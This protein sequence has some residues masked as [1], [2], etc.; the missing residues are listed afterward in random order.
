MTLRLIVDLALGSFDDC[1]HAAVSLSVDRR[2]HLVETPAASDELVL[3]AD[4]LQYQY[5]EGPCLSALWTDGVYL[6][7]DVE[8][9]ERWPSWGPR[10]AELGLRSVLSLRLAT[11]ESILAALNL[12]SEDLDGF[13]GV[14]IDLAHTLATHAGMALAASHKIQMLETAMSTRHTIGM[15]QGILMQRF[16]LGQEQAFRVLVRYSQ[17]HNEKL[18]EVASRIVQRGVT[19]LDSS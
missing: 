18:R 19:A 17:D 1:H 6:S 14:D 10:A 7:P 16:G 8:R 13:D 2:R 12:Y 9:D 11:D 4:E 15:A 5:K 3:R